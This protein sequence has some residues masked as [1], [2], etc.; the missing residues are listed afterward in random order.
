MSR[1][2]FDELFLLITEC[3]TTNVFWIHHIDY[4]K[5]DF[6]LLDPSHRKELKEKKSAFYCTFTSISV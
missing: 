4:M 2:M 5:K 6:V 3:Q 1:R